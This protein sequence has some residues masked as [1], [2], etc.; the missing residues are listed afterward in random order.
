M[1][2]SPDKPYYMSLFA[3]PSKVVSSLKRLLRN[4]FWEGHSG[5]RINHLVKWGRVTLGLKGLSN[6]NTTLLAKWGWIFIEE[7]ES[8][9]RQVVRSIYG[10]E[11]CSWHTIGKFGN[12]L[13]SPWIGISMVRRKLE[14]LTSFKLGNGNRIAFWSDVWVEETSFRTCFSMLFRVSLMPNGSVAALWDNSTL[15]WSIM[16]RRLF[17]EEEI[18]EFQQLLHLLSNRQV[19]DSMDRRFWSLD[20]SSRFSAK[21]FV[22]HL[23]V[24]S[25]LNRGTY[26][27]KPCGSPVVLDEPAS[28]P[29]LW[30]LGL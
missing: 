9:W 25:P 27:V 29:V 15:S 8:L 7:E 24:S 16:F 23:A 1:Q 30:F 18:S 22:N 3:M 20:P 14:T 11:S 19:A 21:S 5:S 12:S 4:C 17:K 2:I 13:K 6:K 10:K 26:K 28:W